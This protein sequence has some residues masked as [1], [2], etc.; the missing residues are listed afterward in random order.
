MYGLVT[1]G[2]HLG[3]LIYHFID[4]QKREDFIEMGLHHIV[5][6]Y[7]FFG[8]YMA[9]VWRIGTVIALLHDLADMVMELSRCLSE[10]QVTTPTAMIFVIGMF[11]WFYT[12]C[13]VLP[14]ECVYKGIYLGCD[15]CVSSELVKNGFIYL[16]MCMVMLHTFWFS[17]FF[18]ILGR[19]VFK[20]KTD[21][22]YTQNQQTW[23]SAKE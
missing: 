4:G 23:N 14:F 22:S 11:V 8:Y 7:L 15:G 17:M 18:R 5:T 13:Y 19:F 20:G 2:Y 9:N 16:L 10:T 3:A 6:I 1:C 21:T 12:R